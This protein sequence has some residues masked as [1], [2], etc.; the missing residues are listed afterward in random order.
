MKR[1]ILLCISLLLTITMD[2]G[3]NGRFFMK[4]SGQNIP[5]ENIVERFAEWFSLPEATEWLEVS[6]TTGITGMDRI[7]YRQYVAGFE[8]EHSQV[9]IHA[10]DGIVTSAN[11]TVME[12]MRS[13]AMR[14]QDSP[15]YKSGTPTGIIGQQLYLVNTPDGYRYAY[16]V[17]SSK[18]HEWVYYDTDTQEVIKRV[19][20]WH[21]SEPYTEKPVKVKVKSIYNGD[22]ML[23]AYQAMDGSVYLYD[24]DRNIHTLSAAY[25]PTFTELYKQGKL[26]YYFPQGDM[27]D[28]YEE[29]TI[30]Q[31]ENWL[32]SLDEMV[33]NNQLDKFPDY[34]LDNCNYIQDNK[35]EFKVFKINDLIFGDITIKD[36]DGNLVP[37]TPG[38]NDDDNDFDDDDD[39]DF[40]DGSNTFDEDD[41]GDGDEDE[42][43][44]ED[45]DDDDDDNSLLLFINIYYGAETPS[46]AIL[47]QAMAD[48]NEIDE[49]PFNY[50]FSPLSLHIPREGATIIPIIVNTQYTSYDTLAVIPFIPDNSGKLE[51]KNDRIS[52]VLEYEPGGNPTADIHWGMG[53]TIDFYKE[54][55]GRDSYDGKGSPVYNLAYNLPETNEVF[56]G[57][58]CTNAA[59]LATQAPYPMVYGLGGYSPFG[60]SRPLVELSVL[61][62]EFTHIVTAHTANLEYCGESGALNE[63]FSD[64][65]GISVKKYSTN[66]DNWYLGEGVAINEE[67]EPYSNT[68]DMAN[69]KNNQDGEQPGPDTYGGEYWE[70]TN[71][72]ENNDD[73]GI[74]T[75]SS[76]QNKWYYLI[77]DGEQGT[78]DNGDNYDVEGI[79][80]EKARQIAYLTLTSYAT[81]QSDYAA[82]RRA[83]LEA[84]E[85]LYGANSKERKTVAKAWDAVGVA[86]SP[87]AAIDA[88]GEMAVNENHEGLVYD[89]QGRVLVGKPTQRGVYI[90]NGKKVVVK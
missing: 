61:A 67:L 36:E 7:E 77:T 49:D 68:R 66:T 47:A 31:R 84:A 11:G 81:S 70:D 24:Q 14:R 25:L 6:R 46:K 42:D 55:F 29:A 60:T 54:V 56:L 86:G 62:H 57:M 5:I 69:P 39:D 32:M 8:V 83:S 9:L 50:T 26:Y 17:M 22:V 1:L 51:F 80:I 12:A 28:N 33:N 71:N 16:K 74:H 53:K 90:V 43:E 75:N 27:P 72:I 85:V 10:K 21:R 89:L 78:N 23:D 2:A 35:K 82:I 40:A 52:L 65:M 45:E 30:E 48:M 18:R 20:T 88:I 34:I 19:G 44:D 38:E 4:L 63:S 87:D 3:N 15:I 37:F 59:A 41:D 64:I 79:G 73:G 13:P 58:D 76:V